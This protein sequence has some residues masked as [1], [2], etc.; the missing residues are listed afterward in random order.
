MVRDFLFSLE[1]MKKYEI[2]IGIFL[3]FWDTLKE[4]VQGSYHT[5]STSLY[6]AIAKPNM[7]SHRPPGE[8][9]NQKSMPKTNTTA[10]GPHEV[11]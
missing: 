6:S 10:G 9:K 7:I 11:H 2:T 1:N 3:T 5:N 8:P 4:N